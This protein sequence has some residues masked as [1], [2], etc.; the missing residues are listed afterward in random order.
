MGQKLSNMVIEMEVKL[1]DRFNEF[2]YKC[3]VLQVRL[4]CGLK[5]EVTDVDEPSRCEYEIFLPLSI[6]IFVCLLLV[7]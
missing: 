6:S 4:R 5:N 3:I 7:V 2:N 1:K